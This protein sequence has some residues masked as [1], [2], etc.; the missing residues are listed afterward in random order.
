L[1]D[2]FGAAFGETFAGAQIERNVGPPPVI[3]ENFC[4][5]EGLRAR[6]R[7]DALLFTIAGNGF[8]T[9]VPLRILTA[10]DGLRDRFQIEGANGLQ[11]FQFFV[12]NGSG[13]ERSRRFDGY[14]RRKLEDVALNH[15]AERTGGFVKTTAAL[16]AERFGGGNLHVVDV[17]A[18]PERLKDAV[19]KAENEQVLHRIFAEV[20]VNA[21]DLIF[22]KDIVDN[23]VEFLGGGE[24]AAKRFFDDD[25]DPRLGITGARKAGA[26]ELLD[27]VGIHFWRR[28]KVKDAI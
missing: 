26:A 15:V 12:A 17:V 9:G 7:A 22:F 13:V 23:L 5:D 21:V 14:E 25:A 16:D 4:G 11:D 27:D 10:N 18:I 19:A 20:V 3:D 24:V 1:N 8:A 6:L 28:R 2:D